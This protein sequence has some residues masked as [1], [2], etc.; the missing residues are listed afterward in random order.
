MN[1]TVRQDEVTNRLNLCECSTECGDWQL[2]VWLQVAMNILNNGRFGMAACLAG[3]MRAVTKKAVD[4]ATTRLQFG[5]RIDSF[6]TVQE[7][8]A[9][10]SILQYVTESLAYMISGNMDK[11]STDFHLEAAISKVVC[12]SERF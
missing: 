10:M 1:Q 8:L 7:K 12:F 3:T 4:H 6:G 5:R 9:R 11:G 2:S